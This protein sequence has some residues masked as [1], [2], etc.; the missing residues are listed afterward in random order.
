MNIIVILFIFSFSILKC[1]N[2]YIFPLHTININ[3]TESELKQD[4]LLKL[5]SNQIYTNFI[6][7]SNQEEIKGLINMSQIGFFIYENAYDF[8]SSSSFNQSSQSRNFYQKNG[9]EGYVAN[10]TLCLVPYDAK[11][12][13][14]NLNIKKCNNFPKV[15]F[16]LL[17]SKQPKIE[18]N[19]YDKYAII[20]LHQS[21]NQ[22]ALQMPVFIK[23][24][25]NTDMI[26][27]HIYSF[28]FY[29]NTKS[30][31]N[32]GYLLIGEDDLDLDHGFLERTH[33]YPKNGQTYWMLIFNKI[34]AGINNS[35]NTSYD[36]HLRS[37]SIKDAQIIGDLSYIIGVKE[38]Q[39]YIRSVFFETL[40][41]KN[42][43]KYQN[44]STTD[45]YGTYVCDGKSDLFIEKYKNEFPKIYFQHGEL[46]T[47][48][49]LDQ[50]DLFTY[51]NLDKTDTKIYF[52]VLFQNKDD[53]YVSP[54]APSK[55][56]IKRWKFGIPFLKKY[57]LYFNNE[58]NIIS[59]FEKFIDDSKEDGDNDNNNKTNLDEKGTNYTWL[60]IAVIA[61]LLI[62]FFVL[63]VLFHKN[64]I[65]LPR[66]K[67]ANEL[68]DDYEYSVNPNEFD[69]KKASLNNYEVP[70]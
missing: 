15:D 25:K 9:E 17:N 68:E 8:N 13:I 27:S 40:L 38:Y 35:Y 53:P 64:I 18:N 20:G 58:E 39:T 26:N 12:D 6:I 41:I 42:I 67:K 14:N 7:G 22:D 48:F 1:E 59:Y 46:N 4:Y 60:K 23:S 63:G 54:E 2:N 62:I 34:I 50:Y 10:D 16:S 45:D 57:K 28:Q 52:L 32:E 21:S 37:F 55:M 44:I 43:C 56:I 31:E 65:R 3:Y 24:L 49:I 5:Y 69:D 30:G 11:I 47:T 61:F 19:I 29:N 36:N 66:K 51:N 33:S 70:N